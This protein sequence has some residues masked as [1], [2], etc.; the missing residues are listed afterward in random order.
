[1]CLLKSFIYFSQHQVDH[2]KGFLH[3]LELEW[4]DVDHCISF[5]NQCL[6]VN[7]ISIIS[8]QLRFESSV[9]LEVQSQMMCTTN[10]P[11]RVG[12]PA[13]GVL[14]SDRRHTLFN[15]MTSS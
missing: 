8:T 6:S 13:A 5:R 1:M 14:T 11:S 4:T 12:Q 3:I 2:I 7:I 9:F 15:D 10:T